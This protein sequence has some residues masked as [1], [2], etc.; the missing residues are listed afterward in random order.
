MTAATQAA[1]LEALTRAGQDLVDAYRERFSRPSTGGIRS[2]APLLREFAE[3]N[4]ELRRAAIASV[5][6][7]P[8]QEIPVMWAVEVDGKLHGHFCATS[9]AGAE[10]IVSALKNQTAPCDM[11]SL[12]IVQLCRAV[13][14]AAPHPTHQG[15]GDAA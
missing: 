3:F 12:K 4:A 1:L 9:Q 14:S 13:L 2:N 8:A 5:E 6:A 15:T 10:G 11:K 7:Q